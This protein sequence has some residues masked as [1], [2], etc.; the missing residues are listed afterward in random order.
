MGR[1]HTD[2]DIVV[3]LPRERMI[4]TGD[5]ITSALSYTGD[6]FVEEWPATLE[7]VMTLDF[8]TVLPGARQRVQG[9][10]SHP[11]P[12]GVL[13]RFLSAGDGAQKAG[14]AA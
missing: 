7:Q 11:E 5:M 6:A 2:G 9:E 3:F 13:A 12:A 4:A 14:R 10:G 1:A 8:D